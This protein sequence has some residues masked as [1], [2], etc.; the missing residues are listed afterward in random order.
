MLEL[1]REVFIDEKM[2]QGAAKEISFLNK[3][4]VRG[5]IVETS[6]YAE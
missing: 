5:I 2:L 1:Q 6:C 3:E 4:S